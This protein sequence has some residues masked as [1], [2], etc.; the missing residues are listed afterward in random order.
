MYKVQ[1]LTRIRTYTYT[2]THTHIRA[3]ALVLIEVGLIIPIKSKKKKNISDNPNYDFPQEC[4]R[5]KRIFFGHVSVEQVT[6]LYIN[7]YT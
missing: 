1:L 2:Y 3:I 5:E 4:R 6:S 7:L